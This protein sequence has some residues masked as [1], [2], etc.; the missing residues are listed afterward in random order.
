MINQATSVKRPF[1]NGLNEKHLQQVDENLEPAVADA[2]IDDP[3]HVAEFYLC[4]RGD[5]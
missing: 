4:S 1:R 3:C 5:V 2:L